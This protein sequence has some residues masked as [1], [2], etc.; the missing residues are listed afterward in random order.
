MKLAG[1]LWRLL[2]LGTLTLAVE[3]HPTVAVR[4]FPSGG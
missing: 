1:H 2:G 4:D 3:F